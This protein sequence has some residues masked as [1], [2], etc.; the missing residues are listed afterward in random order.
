MDLPGLI[1]IL[2]IPSNVKNTDNWAFRKCTGIT[3]IDFN[4][5]NALPVWNGEEI[6]SWFGAIGQVVSTDGTMSSEQ[7]LAYAKEKGLG[8]E[9]TVPSA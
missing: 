8:N 2:T 5:W 6:F 1:G 9:W 4:S 7:L 3:K